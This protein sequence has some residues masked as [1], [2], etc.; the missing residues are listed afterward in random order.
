MLLESEASLE[1]AEK[2]SF[3]LFAFKVA[4]SL[5]HE[6]EQQTPPP[7]EESKDDAEPAEDFRQELDMEAAL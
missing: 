7:D 5:Y 3:S 2:L 1:K 4:L 6:T